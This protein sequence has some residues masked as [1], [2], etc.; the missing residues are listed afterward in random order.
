PNLKVNGPMWPSAGKFTGGA[1]K[2][3]NPPH[4]LVDGLSKRYQRRH[5]SKCKSNGLHPHNL[6]TQGASCPPL[7]TIFSNRFSGGKGHR[8]VRSHLANRLIP[9]IAT[10]AT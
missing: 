2:D 3:S 4:C 10:I 7:Q 1:V 9:E 5:Q 6:S 8:R